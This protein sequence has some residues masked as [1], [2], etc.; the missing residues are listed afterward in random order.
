M[1][2]SKVKK[3]ASILVIILLFPI[4][5]IGCN[6]E[7]NAEQATVLNTVSSSEIT[8]EPTA[9]ITTALE[10]TSEP[11]TQAISKIDLKALENDIDQLSIS[12]STA[13]DSE[14]QSILDTFMTETSWEVSVLYYGN[15]KN[16]FW[17]SPMMELPPDYKFT[18]RPPYLNAVDTGLYIPELYSS[19]FDNKMIQTMCKPII[20]DGKIIGVVGIDVFN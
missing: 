15:Q 18:E 17:T 10:V 8:S 7:P 9:E 6:A 13:R 3:I 11:V 5:M 12:I 2:Q 1:Y 19:A 4:V 16:G 20:V 14:I